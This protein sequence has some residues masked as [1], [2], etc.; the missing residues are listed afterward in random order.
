MATTSQR[1]LAV[2]LYRVFA[3]P[4]GSP[5]SALERTVHRVQ[6]WD[7]EALVDPFMQVATEATRYYATLR[8][9]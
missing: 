3:S 6:R 2:K 7:S 8:G 1:Q 9:S 5:D 4:W